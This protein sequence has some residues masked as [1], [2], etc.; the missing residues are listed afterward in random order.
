MVQVVDAL[1]GTDTLSCQITVQA[2]CFNF[3]DDFNRANGP[4]GSDWSWLSESSGHQADI[5]SNQFADSALG[6]AE[7][8]A[9]PDTNTNGYSQVTMTGFNSQTS[10][11]PMVL[12]S[13][14][15][16]NNNRYV[17]MP[18]DSGPG[19]NQA[20]SI[21]QVGSVGFSIIASTGFIYAPNFADILNIPLRLEFDVQATKV[22]LTAYRNGVQILTVDDTAGT[23][24]TLGKPGISIASTGGGT[25]N[26]WDTFS[27]HTCP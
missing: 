2:A 3:S 13:T 17:L 18:T 22:V 5:I 24:Y 19:T 15:T 1:G 16:I 12:R 9:A 26:T 8:V 10:G 7:V 27:C 4:L 23:R 21:V 25:A 11:G 20:L 6:T 14:V